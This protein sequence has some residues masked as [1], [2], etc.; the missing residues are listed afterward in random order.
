MIAREQFDQLVR[1]VEK[2]VG[3]NPI[4]LR[5]CTAMWAAIGYAGLLAA[6]LVVLLSGAAFLIPA[7]MMKLEDGFAL[8]L[9]GGAILG[10]GGWAVGHALW[11]SIPP[12]EGRVV[13]RLET[14]AL[15]TMLDDLRARLHSAPFH[16]V[17]I[18]ADNNAA[19]RGVPRLGVLGW[20]RN[21]L[22]IGLPLM[23]GLSPDEF[24]AVLAHEFAH[25]SRRHGSFGNWI[26]RLRRSWEQV[27]EWMRR[28][29]VTGTVSIRPLL[30]RYVDWFWPRFNAHAFVLSRANE[31]EADS[32]AARLTAP[33]HIASALLRL[34]V[35]DRFLTEKFWPDIWLAA[36]REPKPPANVFGRLRDFLRADAASVDRAKWV[37]ESF[38][39]ITT[40][41][42]THPCLAD[43]LG[44]LGRLAGKPVLGEH[45][46][47][48][49]PASSSAAEVLLGAA[50]EKLRADVEASWRNVVEPKW[51]DR[52]AK[53]MALQDRLASLQEAVPGLRADVDSL[54]D[55]ARAII[56]LEGDRA[57]VP[58]LRQILGLR[59]AHPL[60]NFCLGRHLIAGDDAT[61]ESYLE[62]A[63]AEDEQ[64]LAD[65][66]RLLHGY[67][68]R[69]G[70]TQRLRELEG[71]L[72]RFEKMVVKSQHEQR[73]VT[74]RDVLV[75]H[76]L[77][78]TIL[79]PLQQLLSADADILA[80]HLG[81]KQLQHFPKQRLFVLCVRIRPA[82]YGL[83]DRDREHRVINRLI[84]GVRLPGRVFVCAPS[85]ANAALARKLRKLPTTEIF[86]RD[87]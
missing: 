50:Q 30:T 64:L 57:A 5:L 65:G 86:R 77:D 46:V 85:G 18:V 6:F 73:S 22:V 72:D 31:Y 48:S 3:Q 56:D 67:F 13:T 35:A 19:V 15:F 24:R 79:R 55:K 76:D 69:T 78:A 23:D 47:L 63:I 26:Y 28:P 29:R 62:Q 42:D 36:N 37:A 38:R 40:N 82:W 9:L 27:F 41:A 53:A 7:V 44:A 34:A 1:S 49:P 21:H 39:A 10:F 66:S 61:G 45:S 4:T 81:R 87:R 12:P 75:S 68:R 52:H 83:R 60:A 58:L 43:R 71:R 14:P 80:A 17:V 84:G 8:Y 74:A 16:R 54:W 59:P 2:G 70:Q 25:L 51:R 33:T 20:S 32:V 11:V